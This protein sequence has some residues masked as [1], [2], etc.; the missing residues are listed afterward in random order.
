M[1]SMM[2]GPRLAPG[3]L[4]ACALVLAACATATPAAPTATDVSPPQNVVSATTVTAS[5][6]VVPAASAEMAFLVSAPVREIFASEGEAVQEG[7]PIVALDAQQLEY[8]LVAAEAAYR[9][10]ERNEYIQSQGRRKIIDNKAVWV[11]GSPEQRQ[12]AHAMTLRA[13]AGVE[14]A[15]AEFSRAALTAPF[16]G[17]VVQLSTSLGELVQ[18]GQVVVVFGDLANLRIETT[19]LSETDVARVKVG[20]KARITLD[21]LANTISGT[22]AAIQPKAGRS[23]DGDVIYK[24]MIDLDLQP[25]QLLWGMTGEVQ[26]EVGPKS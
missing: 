8:A 20:Q 1:G 12:V 13:Q 6:R 18:P 4:A 10:A 5:V 14:A 9:S 25:E 21:A 7:D 19:D 16:D 22:V 17:T 24:V 2:R 15:L 26:I 23:P 3:F 11:S